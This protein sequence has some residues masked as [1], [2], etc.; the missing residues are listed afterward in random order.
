MKKNNYY[1][2]LIIKLVISLFTV[3]FT[4]VS[5]AQ[6]LLNYTVYNRGV[7]SHGGQA[8]TI[9]YNASEHDVWSVIYTG[10]IRW[11]GNTGAQRTITFSTGVDDWAHLMIN[12]T[13]VF[14]NGIWSAQGSITLTE[15]QI[16][17]IYFYADN[18]GGSNWY[19][20]LT[21]DP[22]GDG[23]FTVLTS[24]WIGLY[25]GTHP[26]WYDSSSSSISNDQTTEIN[27]IRVRQSTFG[28]TTDNRILITS[29]GSNSNVDIIQESRKNSV[30]GMSGLG[31][32]LIT[33]NNNT[34][35]IRQGNGNTVSENN[36]IGLSI[37]GNSNTLTLLQGW[38][39]TWPTVSTDLAESGNHV[40]L[41][42]VIGDLNQVTA[43]QNNT[44]LSGSGHYL[45]ASIT[46]SN[47]QVYASQSDGSSSIYHK[48]FVD[49]SGN[50]NSANIQQQGTGAKFLDIMMVGN[51][52]Q[53]TVN[54]Q[55]TASH[56]ARIN[57]FNS[58]GPSMVNLTQQGTVP[59]IYNLSQYCVV[60]SG[61][62]VTLT[63]GTP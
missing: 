21:W 44:G 48:L 57:L 4:A 59:Q 9:W 41:I 13:T 6:F 11:P 36:M 25:P 22:E 8:S 35:R 42:D 46:G 60:P 2:D 52:H 1:K 61:C 55:G 50:Y 31:D 10:Y 30:V 56:N 43:I 34:V 33:G 19:Y 12:N 29:S 54:Q 20:G 40:A 27:T 23:S 63:Q 18:R 15:G 45:S 62:S 14:N 38:S 49:I 47:N 17:P 16:Y 51:N 28:M 26:M 5:H 32:A 7:P 39:G 58:G 24:P 37:A 53:L 3:L